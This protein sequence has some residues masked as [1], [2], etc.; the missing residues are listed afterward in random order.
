MSK[1]IVAYWSQSGN[2]EKMAIAIGKGIEEA[3]NEAEVLEISQVSLE[4]LKR[5]DR[6]ALGCPSMGMEVLEENEM[7][8][9]VTDVEKFAS[10]KK[11][12]LFGSYGWGDGQWMREWVE[13]MSNAGANIVGSEGLIV[14]E[15]PDEAAENDCREFGKKLVNM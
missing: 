10:G 8:P 12:G 11:I 5:A 15:T 6:F 14:Q 1:I 9:F 4:D 2:T 7:E 3:G 13:R